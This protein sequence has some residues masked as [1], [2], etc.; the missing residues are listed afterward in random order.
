[1]AI[2]GAGGAFTSNRLSM[3]MSTSISSTTFPALSMPIKQT[4][5]YNV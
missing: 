5:K 4:N 1:M 3:M 2:D